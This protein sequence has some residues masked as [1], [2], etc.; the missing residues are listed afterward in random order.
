MIRRPPR[1]TRTDTLFPYTTLFR[2]S[3]G[4]L[5][6]AL[7]AVSFEPGSHALVSGGGEARRRY[8]AWGLFHVE[9]D[10][11]PLWRRYACALQQ[12][13][14]LLKQRVR[15]GQLD[16]WDHELAEVGE[17]MPHPRGAYLAQLP[18]PPAAISGA[19]APPLGPAGPGVHPRSE[20][21]P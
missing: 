18:V 20:Q 14:S 12:R 3:L 1:S 13:N 21:S 8:V 2:S 4:D 16:A 17:P 19:L 5:C 7:A 11:L 9:P 15:D 6:A 10:F